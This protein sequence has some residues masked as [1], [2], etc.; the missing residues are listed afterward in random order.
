LRS[1]AARVVA[2]QCASR[3]AT[4]RV[5][6]WAAATTTTTWCHQTTAERNFRAAYERMAVDTKRTAERDRELYADSLEL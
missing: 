5:A 3:S 1:D 6:S 2:R 4:Y